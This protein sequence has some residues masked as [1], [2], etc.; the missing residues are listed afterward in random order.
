MQP[1]PAS[2][3]EEIQ[4]HHHVLVV[5]DRKSSQ[6]SRKGLELKDIGQTWLDGVVRYSS[7]MLIKHYT[8]GWEMSM[9]LIFLLKVISPCKY[10]HI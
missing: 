7:R 8:Y 10:A 9:K 2:S 1:S 3:K 4:S 6:N 5:F